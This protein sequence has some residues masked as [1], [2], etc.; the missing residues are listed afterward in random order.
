MLQIRFCKY[1]LPEVQLNRTKHENAR[2]RMKDLLIIRSA[3]EPQKGCRIRQLQQ[4]SKLHTRT[5]QITINTCKRGERPSNSLCK[6]KKATPH[7][8]SFFLSAL[9]EALCEE[10]DELR[11]SSL[12]SR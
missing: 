6:R 1:N 11:R 10:A 4:A 12:L 2:E 7:F 3:V 5:E 8:F 9:S